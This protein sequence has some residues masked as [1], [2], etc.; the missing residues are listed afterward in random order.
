MLLLM[1][2]PFWEY[3]KSKQLTTFAVLAQEFFHSSGGIN[4]LLLAGKERMT[5]GTDLH[6]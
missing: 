5:I 6:V 2:I 1:G 3:V 4:Q